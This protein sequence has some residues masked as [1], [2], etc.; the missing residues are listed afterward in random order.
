MEKIAI[1]LIIAAAL[2]YLIFSF[3]AASLDITTWSFLRRDTAAFLFAGISIYIFLA[4]VLFPEKKGRTNTNT[5]NDL[6]HFHIPR[7]PKH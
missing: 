2:I 5:L 4:N 1:N 3:G 7:R 6:H